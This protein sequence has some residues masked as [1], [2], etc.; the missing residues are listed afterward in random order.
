MMMVIYFM[1]NRSQVVF[2]P[3]AYLLTS[4]MAVDI[5]TEGLSGFPTGLYAS[6]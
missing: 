5:L 1:T 6:I 3:S 4:A 2:L